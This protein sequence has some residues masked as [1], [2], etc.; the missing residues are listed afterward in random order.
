MRKSER[1][2]LIERL[3]R[4]QNLSTQAEVAAAL[5]SAGASVTQATVS[6]DLRE[7]GVQKGS[8]RDGRPR[9]AIPGRAGRNPAAAL[10]QILVD[11]EAQWQHAQNLLVIRSLPGTAPAVGRVLDELNHDDVI[12]T[13]AGDDTVLVITADAAR[14]KKFA[15]F[16]E[17]LVERNQTA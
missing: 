3:I 13:V 12:G 2:Q 8:G 4:E 10:E 16:L 14:A 15:G 7:L 11:A 6:R 17:Q 5:Q 9:F 1:Q